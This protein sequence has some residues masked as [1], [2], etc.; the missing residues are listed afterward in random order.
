MNVQLIASAAKDFE[1]LSPR[2]RKT[3][4]KQLE[5]LCQDLCHPSI[6]AKKY[7]E[8]KDVWQGRVNRGYRFYFRICRHH[9]P[10]PPHHS[11]PEV[12]ELSIW[13]WRF[14]SKTEQSDWCECGVSDF[15]YAAWNSYS[16]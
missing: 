9:L 6:R 5:L 8:S 3:T 2:L 10:Y 16:C 1:E 14:C 11:A 13:L 7:D 4:L 12:E 15:G